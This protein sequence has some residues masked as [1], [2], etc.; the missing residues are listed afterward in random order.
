[1]TARTSD[2]LEPIQAGDQPSDPM[3]SRTMSHT[4][5][6]VKQLKSRLSGPSVT[7]DL[8]DE[9]PATSSLTLGDLPP[10]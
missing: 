4:V 6:E 10:E 3:R 8:G 1:M 2:L 9:P 7:A 5:F